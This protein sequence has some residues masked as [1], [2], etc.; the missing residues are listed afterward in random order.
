MQTFDTLKFEVPLTLIKSDLP[1]SHWLHA[2]DSD[3]GR[4]ATLRTGSGG[5]GITGAKAD[6]R[7]E[8]LIG[9]VSAKLLADDY[10]RGYS[11]DTI[12]QGMHELCRRLQIIADPCEL[13]EGAIIHRCDPVNMV[14]VPG[15]FDDPMR[16]IAA[17]H[18]ANT[19]PEYRTDAYT[20]NGKVYKN[21]GVAYTASKKTVRSRFE[22]YI[23]Y[24][25]MARSNRKNRDFFGTC[26]NPAAMLSGMKNFLRIEQNLTAHEKIRKFFALPAGSPM[27][28]ELLTSQARPNLALFNTITGPAPSPL[29][30]LF[31]QFT[32][33]VHGW[34]DIAYRKG[35][36]QIFSGLYHTA[37][38]AGEKQLK[39]FIRQFESDANYKAIV[40]DRRG[41]PGVQTLWRQYVADQA[42][43]SPAPPHEVIQLI[44]THLA[45]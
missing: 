32:P 33:G 14:P 42:A 11:L 18:V 38:P 12:E 31:D 19:N 35:I 41:K 27:L 21:M 6:F 10:L 7:T 2:S 25:D 43:A 17:L 28:T 13:I 45:A 26:Y 5:P 44:K 4:I 37:G 20:I 15:L 9:E 23:K 39:T 3:G 16:T 22:A 8:K 1:A 29:L 40:Y 30:N 36:E 24:F 34:K